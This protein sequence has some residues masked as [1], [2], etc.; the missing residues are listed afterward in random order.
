MAVSIADVMRHVHNF[1]ERERLAGEFA[2]QD[3]VLTPAVSAPYAA[4]YG[5]AADGVYQVTDGRLEGWTGRDGVFTGV[6]WGL[7]PPKDFLDVCASASAYDA[8]NP[9][10]AYLSESFGNYSYTR[11]GG[12]S[13]SAAG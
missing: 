5:S 13:G 8:K 7:Y 11:A 2:V 1:F 3:G 4:I 12:Q 6:V 9:A 10:G